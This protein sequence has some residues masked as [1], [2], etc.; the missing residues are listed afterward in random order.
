M[1]LILVPIEDKY[2]PLIEQWLKKEYI[3]KWYY[4]SD[5]WICV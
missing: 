1:N 5:E 3:L 2:I 4:G